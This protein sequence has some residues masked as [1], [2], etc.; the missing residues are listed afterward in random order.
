MKSY[1]RS[2]KQLDSQ[3]ELYGGLF[4]SYL[5]KR[6]FL[7]SIESKLSDF[8]KISRGVPP[9]SIIGAPLF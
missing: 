5:S 9:G 8:G 2:L 6:I 7:V 1:Y 4:R 3:R